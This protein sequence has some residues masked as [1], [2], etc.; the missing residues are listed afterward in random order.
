MNV[1]SVL[2]DLDPAV[3]DL[4]LLI[5]TLTAPFVVGLLQKVFKDPLPRLWAGL[6]YCMLIAIFVL[7]AT[8]EIRWP[9]FTSDPVEVIEE[10][11]GAMSVVY[12]LALVLWEV[13]KNQLERVVE[14]VLR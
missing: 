8:G 2:L 12:T 5:L 4:A 3:T 6:G 13:L 9:D 7:T 10:L 1:L 14:A 11:L